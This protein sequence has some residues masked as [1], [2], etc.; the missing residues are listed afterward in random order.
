MSPKRVSYKPGRAVLVGNS[1]LENARKF[2]DELSAKMDGLTAT[3][4][5][6]VQRRMALDFLRLVVQGTPVDTGRARGGW[7]VEIGAPVRRPTL[8]DRSGTPT[9]SR[10]NS[11]LTS[12]AATVKSAGWHNKHRMQM[13]RAVWIMNNVPYI[14]VLERGFKRDRRTGAMVPWSRRGHGFFARGI[15]YLRSQFKR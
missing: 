7:H 9:I 10:G 11:A 3:E 5:S 1:N 4:V 2:S 13:V 8:N 6:T 12:Y 14:D 15:A